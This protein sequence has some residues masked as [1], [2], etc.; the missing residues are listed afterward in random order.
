LK[1]YRDIIKDKRVKL[2]LTQNQLA[3]LAGISQPFM[4]EIESG[5]KAPSIDVLQKICDVLSIEMFC[6]KD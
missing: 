5:R 6:D 3:K 2:G 4:N 1:S